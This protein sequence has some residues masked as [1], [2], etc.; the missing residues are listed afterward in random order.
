MT[1]KTRIKIC[2]VRDLETARCAARAGA[3]YVGLVF[4][5]N[6]PRQVTTR[7]ACAIV[8]GLDETTEA[9]VLFADQPLQFV[10]HVLDELPVNLVQLHGHENRAYIEA[11]DDKTIFKAVPFDQNRIKPW[12]RAPHH[13]GALLIDSP[14]SPGEPTGGHGRAFNWPG[15]S[16][17]DRVDLP[18]LILAG[19]LT[20]DNV[21]AA[22]QTVQPWGVDVSSGVEASRGVKDLR[23]IREFCK[24]VR[25]ADTNDGE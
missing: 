13:V 21:G 17:L 12:R 5:T 18:P 16:D 19:G 14:T 11:L 9:V 23:L 6:S 4:V 7:Q 25:Q 15:L 8:E 10:R 3:Q 1:A 2:G 20:P 22:V 24:A